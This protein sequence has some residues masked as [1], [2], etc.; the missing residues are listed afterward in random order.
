MF[1]Y[2][3]NPLWKS[4]IYTAVQKFGV[5]KIFYMFLKEVFYV[6]T[7]LHLSHQ[8]YNNNSNIVK[9]ILLC[10]LSLLINWVHCRIKVLFSFFF[11]QTFK[12]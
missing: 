3:S 1:T 8:K 4:E 12:K 7:W 9:Q 11:K 10:S 5:D 2:I 6:L